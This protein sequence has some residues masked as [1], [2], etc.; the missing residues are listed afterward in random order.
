MLCLCVDIQNTLSFNCS[1]S[2][3]TFTLTFPEE[4]LKT[5]SV[6]FN[7]HFPHKFF[8][9]NAAECDALRGSTDLAPVL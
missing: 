1:S 4:F 8:L 9:A 6:A 3:F 7:V 2:A 5:V